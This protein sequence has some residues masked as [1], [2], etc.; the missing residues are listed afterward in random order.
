M[1]RWSHGSKKISIDLLHDEKMDDTLG[2]HKFVIYMNKWVFA[3][4]KNAQ[5]HLV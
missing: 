1:F 2:N 3:Q 4:P 5:K